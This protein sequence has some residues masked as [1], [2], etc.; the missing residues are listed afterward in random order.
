MAHHFN[1][2]ALSLVTLVAVPPANAMAMQA[3]TTIRQEVN[4]SPGQL[5]EIR[6]QTGAAV[7][8]DGWD[9]NVVG[10]TA[11]LDDDA[12][13]DS[14]VD[15]ARTTSGASIESRYVGRSDE[16]SCDLEIAV[17]V[18][19][20]FNVRISSMGGAITIR[21]VTG[22]FDGRTNGG[23][24]DLAGLHGQVH[25]TTLGG[26]IKLDDSELDGSLHTNGGRVIFTNV[27]GR[28]RGTT[29]GGEVVMRG[30]RSQTGTR[31]AVRVRSMGGDIRVDSA[32][33]GADVHTNGGNVLIRSA[34]GHV[35]AGTNGGRIE[36]QAVDGGIEAT[37][38][39][40]DI[41]ARMV[42]N[43][44]SGERDVELTS[45]SGDVTLVVP[46]ALSMDVDITLAY[47]INSRQSYK[48]ESD[49][50]LE[51]SGT[52]EWDRSEGTARKFYYATGKV[53][54]G[55]HRIRIQT[56][57]GNVVLKKGQ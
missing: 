37:T 5:L 12:C 51:R 19:R 55:K 1:S 34:T 22:D 41:S 15:V 8:I 23:E 6:L 31:N 39:G 10:V 46:A 42:G 44:S 45:Y 49:F 17:K 33:S 3:D 11:D 47:T 56:I 21:N 48:I 52:S 43:P 20:K 25:L 2:L 35:K 32:P 57:N 26:D 13:P 28:V 36:L 29:N 7:R 9:R 4:V 50:P 53:G 16:R 54:D 38:M 27:S 14:R 40:G 30:G 24:L 18:P